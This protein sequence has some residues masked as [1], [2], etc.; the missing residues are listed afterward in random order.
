YDEQFE[1]GVFSYSLHSANTQRYFAH[2]EH[3]KQAKMLVARDFL[4]NEAPDL[5]E[6]FDNKMSNNNGRK[7]SVF[8]LRQTPVTDSGFGKTT[9]ARTSSAVT[10]SHPYSRLSPAALSPL[11]DSQRRSVAA[12]RILGEIDRGE[13]IT[14]CDAFESLQ[15][16]LGLPRAIVNCSQLG[17]RLFN[18]TVDDGN[19]IYGQAQHALKPQAKLLAYEDAI[20]S[21]APEIWSK[22]RVN[23]YASYQ[24]S[25][26]QFQSNEDV[27]HEYIVEIFGLSVA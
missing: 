15:E 17:N 26:R 11:S 2:H 7:C 12:C 18:V 6:L 25:I 23:E 27:L 8:K 21:A 13:V 3:K 4:R 1:N 14:P 19:R 20:R 16:G 24:C 10:A 5:L 22:L 9:K